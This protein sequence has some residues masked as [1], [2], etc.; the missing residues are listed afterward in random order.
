[1]FRAGLQRDGVVCLRGVFSDTCVAD[2][3]RGVERNLAEPGPNMEVIACLKKC[4][5]P[6]FCWET[7]ALPAT[8]GR[9]L[10]LRMAPLVPHVVSKPRSLA[11]TWWCCGTWTIPE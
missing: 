4:Q 10:D 8:C 5:P 2:V 11:D 6:I 7:S 1:M 9:P 3:R